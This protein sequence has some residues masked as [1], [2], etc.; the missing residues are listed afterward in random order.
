[1]AS[2]LTIQTTR[3]MA[4]VGAGAVGS[5]I[6]G[7]ISKAHE[8][9]TLI[10]SWF[11]HIESI[12]RDG[13]LIDGTR[14]RHLVRVKSLHTS[15]IHAV[16][17]RFDLLFVSV[18]S[19]DTQSMVTF[20]KPYLKEDAW[21]I[22]CQ[23]G[24]NEDLLANIVGPSCTIG[25]VITMGAEMVG[26]GSV[27]ET[28][29]RVAFITGE[30]DGR[31]TPRIQEIAKILRLCSE[32][33]ITTNLYGERWSKLARN[34]MDNPLVVL[35]DWS[36]AQ[37]HED[38][39]IRIIFQAIVGEIIQVAEAMGHKMEPILGI[40]AETWKKSAIIQQP[41]VDKALLDE[42]RRLG[43]RRFSLYD[44]V[45][46]GRPTEIDYLTGYVVN[47]GRKMRIAVPV[48]ELIVMLVKDIQLGKVAAQPSNIDLL[49]ER[50]PHRP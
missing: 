22:S 14:G 10:D 26:P 33:R 9:I 8:D 27:R 24:M 47:Q 41:E 32:T 17:D 49:W 39:R 21:V 35:T 46:R 30:L 37:L 6:G 40:D 43:D 16:T 48:N 25:C 20:M 5:V 12:K 45:K 11:E 29:N 36:A 42:G 44:D 38:A 34:C 4:L 19:Y 28:G 13:L 50:I 2:S 3:K 7:Y 18:K 23:N 1:L 15:E 31:I